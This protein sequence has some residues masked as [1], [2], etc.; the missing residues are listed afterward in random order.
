M[1][2]SHE[3][4]KGPAFSSFFG[5]MTSKTKDNYETAPAMFLKEET[6]CTQ[7]VRLYAWTIYTPT[8]KYVH[9]F[10]KCPRPLTRAKEIL[11]VCLVTA[12]ARANKI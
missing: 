12:P 4:N 3:R 1:R 10:L 7:T 8:I 11:R 5:D 9:L 6:T 2:T